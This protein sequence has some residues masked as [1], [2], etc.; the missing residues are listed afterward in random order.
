MLTYDR[1]N[2]MYVLMSHVSIAEYMSITLRL[3]YI[4]I[5]SIPVAFVERNKK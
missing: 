5:N 2:I 3:T 1:I 4:G